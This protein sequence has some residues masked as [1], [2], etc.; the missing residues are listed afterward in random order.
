MTRLLGTREM[1][2]KRE[3]ERVVVGAADTRFS[4]LSNSVLLSIALSQ[5]QSTQLH[6]PSPTPPID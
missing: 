5:K 6:L 3:K 1:G 2:G 4:P